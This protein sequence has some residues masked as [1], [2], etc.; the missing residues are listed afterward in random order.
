V[1]RLKTPF[2][3]TGGTALS[4]FYFNHRYSDD[5]DLFVNNSKAYLEFIKQ[6][7]AKFEESQKSGIFK[8]NYNLLQRSGDY[9]QI[10]LSKSTDK[11]EITLKIDL[12]N[13]IS[14]HFGKFN[15]DPTLGKVDS[16]EN[17]LSNKLAALFRFEPKDIADIWVISKN[18]LFNWRNIIAEAKSKEA[19]IDPVQIHRIL[20]SFPADE[21]KIIKWAGRIEKDQIM[22][23]IKVIAIDILQGNKNSLFP[24]SPT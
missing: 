16:W 20:N 11:G 5:L 9:T 14:K 12:V 8:I 2:Y 7:L 21:L 15:I 6:I 4:R 13:D 22:K 23:D 19:A 17:I 1:S 10:F 24:H 3:L 18:R